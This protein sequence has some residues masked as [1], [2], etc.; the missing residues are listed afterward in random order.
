MVLQRR[1]RPQRRIDGQRTHLAAPRVEECAMIAE[2]AIAKELSQH[3]KR[4]QRQRLIDERLPP[5]QCLDCRATRERV[6]SGSASAISGYNSLTVRIGVSAYSVTPDVPG[7]LRGQL[8]SPDQ[9]ALLLSKFE[10]EP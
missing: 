5:V 4:V 6:F 8:P 3:R 9:V 1:V 2:L 10:D 7:N